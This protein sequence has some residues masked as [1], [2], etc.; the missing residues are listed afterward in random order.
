VKLNHKHLEIDACLQLFG[1]QAVI[2]F[3]I[4]GF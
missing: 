1:Q 2:A 4:T 3:Q